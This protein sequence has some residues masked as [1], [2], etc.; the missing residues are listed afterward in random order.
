MW[1]GWTHTSV[2]RFRF[3]TRQAC[4]RQVTTTAIGE[5]TFYV[6]ALSQR[7]KRSRGRKS[8][9]KIASDLGCWDTIA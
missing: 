9:V 6:I 1:F 5:S 3:F 2:P 7:R 8:A 4:G